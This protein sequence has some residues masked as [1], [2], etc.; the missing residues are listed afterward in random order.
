MRFIIGIAIVFYVGAKL[1]ECVIQEV[2]DA[3]RFRKR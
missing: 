2:R 1:I 3:L